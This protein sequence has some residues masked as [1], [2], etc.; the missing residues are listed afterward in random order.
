VRAK[1]GVEGGHSARVLR[2]RFR[3][4]CVGVNQP[5][6]PVLKYCPNAHRAA[7]PPPS[8]EGVD[9]RGKILQF[10]DRGAGAPPLR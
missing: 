2:R 7:V 4:K 10:S 8:N 5:D 9:A 1:L 6:V 3:A